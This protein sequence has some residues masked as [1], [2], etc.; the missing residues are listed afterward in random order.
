[1]DGDF[2][3]RNWALL[4]A[5]LLAVIV[6]LFV[7]YHLYRQSA[8]ARL[9]AALDRLRAGERKAAAAK[10][11]LAKASA[12]LEKL[13]SRAASVR[14]RV[15]EEASEAVEDARLARKN[16]D[17]Q[18]LVARNEMRMAIVEEYPPKRHAALRRHYLG[19]QDQHS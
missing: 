6:F 10:R 5:A 11:A 9:G 17:D 12:R 1:V 19:E 4:L 7:A 3:I 8:Q 2:A 15:L 16:A 13:R 14:P 18:L